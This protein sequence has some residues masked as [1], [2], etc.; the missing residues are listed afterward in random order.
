MF[1]LFLKDFISKPMALTF[2]YNM[3][4]LC[5]FSSY[6]T[7]LAAIVLDNIIRSSFFSAPF[8]LRQCNDYTTVRQGDLQLGL[9]L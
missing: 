4:E 3:S 2:A 8:S 9:S 1:W 5:L 7:V 6:L